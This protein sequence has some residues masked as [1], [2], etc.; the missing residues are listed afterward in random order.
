MIDIAAVCLVLT[1]RCNIS[2][3]H[4]GHNCSDQTRETMT[5]EEAKLYIEGACSIPSLRLLGFTGGEPFLEYD[6]L[7]DLISLVGQKGISSEV[8]TNG[9]WADTEECARTLLEPL[10]HRG[11]TNFVTSLDEY[12]LEQI[13]LASI[14]NGVRAAARLGL[15]VTVKTTVAPGG[16]ISAADPA[17][18]LGMDPARQNVRYLCDSLVPAGRATRLLC[19]G[20]SVAPEVNLDGRCQKVIRFPIVFPGGATFP[21]CGF[22]DGARMAGNARDTPFPDV[23]DALR[24]DLSFNLLGTLGPQGI[25]EAIRE[26]GS[27]LPDRSF[28]SHCE[29]CNFLYL[30]P[31]ARRAFGRWMRSLIPDIAR[32]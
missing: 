25:W 3:R 11:L 5:R 14:Q 13:P 2:C 22:G 30:N 32:E 26:E 20:T 4:C 8:V 29:Q 23:L 15:N 24:L 10:V 28:S 17:R 7:L 19:D 31:E 16:T 9:S 12:H 27:F 18:L 6:L 1:R 21:C